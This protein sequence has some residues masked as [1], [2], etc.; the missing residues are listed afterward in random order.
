MP[1]TARRKLGSNAK[2]KDSSQIP[3]TSRGK[4]TQNASDGTVARTAKMQLRYKS[5]K[6]PLPDST[7]HRKKDPINLSMI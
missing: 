4:S 2:Y 5:I 6:L 3:L 1:L 7:L